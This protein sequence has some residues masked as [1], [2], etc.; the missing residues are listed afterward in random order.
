M[1]KLYAGLLAAATIAGT[2]ITTQ[3]WA[4]RSGRY[5]H[6]HARVG[7]YIGAPLF[8]SPFWY[9]YPYY[10]PPATV[11]VRPAA[12]VVYIEQADAAQPAA[13]APQ[14]QQQ[15]WHYCTDSKTYYPYVNTCASPWQRVIPYPP[16]PG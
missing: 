2:L 7:V 11:V 5:H 8:W 12:P 9:P 3:A 10:Y 6:H 15:Y 16:P 1:N 4:Q 13:P 14:M